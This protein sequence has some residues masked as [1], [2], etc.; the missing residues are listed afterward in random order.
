MRQSYTLIGCLKRTSENMRLIAHV[1]KND[2]HKKTMKGFATEIEYVISE[3]NEIKSGTACDCRMIRISP[4]VW[5]E[6]FSTNEEDLA[7]FS[8]RSDPQGEPATFTTTYGFKKSNVPFLKAVTTWDYNP[9]LPSLR[10]N[11]YEE[12]WLCVLS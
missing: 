10:N 3:L 4:E 5:E 2:R 12:Y 7:I 6:L 8:S 11:K 9:D 1:S